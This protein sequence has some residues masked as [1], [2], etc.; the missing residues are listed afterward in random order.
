[1]ETSLGLPEGS[2][3]SQPGTGTA[4][5]GTHHAGRSGSG[6]Q[7]RGLGWFSLGLGTAQLAAPDAMSRLCG[8]DDSP[9]APAVM[10][11]AG[12]REWG[13]GAMLLGS[14]RP[15]RW[16]WTRVAGDLLDLAILGV[17]AARRSGGRRRRVVLAATAVAGVTAFDVLT[18]ARSV[19]AGPAVQVGA[20]ITVYSS[21]EEVY[22]FWRDFKRL[23][24]FMYH[25][26]SVEITG[27]H[28]SHWT[29]RAPVG[30]SV[31]WDAEIVEDRPGELIRWRSAQGARVRNAGE[32][33]FASAPGGRGTEVRV[34]LAYQPP[35]GAL[36][37]A[38]AKL[39]GEEPEQQI[40][41]DLRRFKQ[42][43][44]TGEIARSEGSP[45]GTAARQQL[46]Q[47][48]ARPAAEQEGRRQRLAPAW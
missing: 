35:A 47:R 20:S 30:Q 22:R 38:V 40:R 17:A 11:V 18:A 24:E 39:F 42:V 37:V 33:R 45:L 3:G 2:T 19:K 16:A 21:P 36:G 29:A 41:D 15:A 48:P 32:V 8:V 1:V 10:R 26:A 13:H 23:P 25:L 34:A 4:G 46:Q 14:K 31:E 9:V 27:D 6:R 7:A 43:S 5:K 28:T 44:E 12:L